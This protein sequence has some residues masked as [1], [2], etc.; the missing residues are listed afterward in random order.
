MGCFHGIE[1]D[2]YAARRLFELL[3]DAVEGI[4]RSTAGVGFDV[5]L[6]PVVDVFV[7]DEEF[8]PLLGLGKRRV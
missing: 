8:S 4:A 6:H 7:G 3:G 2:E 5:G 1:S